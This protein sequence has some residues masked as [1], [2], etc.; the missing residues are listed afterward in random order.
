MKQRAHLSFRML[1]VVV[2]VVA[3]F[4]VIGIVFASSP[5]AFTVDGFG[6]GAQ[7]IGHFS[8]TNDPHV[9]VTAN[10]V[11]APAALGGY[12]TVEYTTSWASGSFFKVSTFIVNTTTNILGFSA[13]SGNN[14]RCP[15]QMGWHHQ[16]ECP[17]SD[18]PRWR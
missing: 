18:R 14:T 3:A 11:A 5:N 8:T 6:S 16:P 4:G 17:E 12:R 13:P 15:Y 2:A 9:D 10:G 7:T 1:V